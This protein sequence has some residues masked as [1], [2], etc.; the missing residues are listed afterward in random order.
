MPIKVTYQDAN[1]NPIPDPATA[2][3]TDAERDN[4]TKMF[5]EGY[6]R[7]IPEDDIGKTKEGIKLLNDFN[8]NQA[9]LP[10]FQADQAQKAQAQ[11]VQGALPE[12]YLGDQD[13]HQDKGDA[14]YRGYIQYLSQEGDQPPVDYKTNMQAFVAHENEVKKALDE[15]WVGFGDLTQDVNYKAPGTQSGF[16]GSPGLSSSNTTPAADPRFPTRDER[17]GRVT[18]AKE[19]PPVEVASN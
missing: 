4:W 18:P 14:L 2:P 12:L 17:T 6:I 16:G 13:T 5:G 8:I 3:I 10:A 19:Q 9:R 1:G 15:Q 7:H 11:S